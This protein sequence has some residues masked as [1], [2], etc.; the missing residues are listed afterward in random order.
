VYK[1]WQ[2]SLFSVNVDCAT[3]IAVESNLRK[4]LHQ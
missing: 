1:T 4:D 2:M 3:V